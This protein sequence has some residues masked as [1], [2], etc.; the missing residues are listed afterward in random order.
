MGMSLSAIL[1][2]SCIKPA[3]VIFIRSCSRLTLLNIY[4]HPAVIDSFRPTLVRK[5]SFSWD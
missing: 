4:A 2:S 3:T 1:T 5:A